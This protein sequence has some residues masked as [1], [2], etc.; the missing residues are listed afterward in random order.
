[1][2]FEEYKGKNSHLGQFKLHPTATTLKQK[3]S[4]LTGKAK[5]EARERIYDYLSTMQG[6]KLS[7]EAIR[8]KADT[9]SESATRRVVD[10]LVK[11]GRV[12]R[13][14][15]AGG[16]L[17]FHCHG[18]IKVRE[19]GRLQPQDIVLDIQK[20]FSAAPSPAVAVKA[21]GLLE[22]ID[23]MFLEFADNAGDHIIGAN[24]FRRFVHKKLMKEEK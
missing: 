15:V 23:K 12:T 14:A 21:V 7:Y 8:I 22:D 13:R 10:E 24:A 17:R 5:E 18:E 4:Y 3:R 6:K 19:M 1:M 2:A 20:D 11:S 16:G 9:P